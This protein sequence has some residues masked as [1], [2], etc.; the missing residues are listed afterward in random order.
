M[1][2]K[3]KLTKIRSGVR[4]VFTRIYNKID[5][6]DSDS[7]EFQTRLLELSHVHSRLEKLDNEILNELEDEVE[8]ENDIEQS[9]SYTNKFLMLKGSAKQKEVKD[10]LKENVRLP[11][12]EMPIFNGN[13]TEFMPFFE[14]FTKTIDERTDLSKIEKFSYLK[15]LLKDDAAKSIEGLALTSGNYDNAL[16]IL[17]E[18]FGNKNKIIS[19]HVKELLQL[20]VLSSAKGKALRQMC[21][22]VELHIRAL[23]TMGVVANEYTCFLKEIVLSRLPQHL[24]ISWARQPECDLGDVN[25]LMTFLKKEAS[26][27]E[28]T[29][30]DADSRQSWRSSETMRTKTMVSYATQKLNCILCQQHHHLY[31]C[32]TFHQ[33]SVTNRREFVKKKG[34][35]FRCLGKHYLKNCTFNIKCKHCNSRSHNPYLHVE[36]IDNSKSDLKEIRDVQ[37]METRNVETQV[38][39]AYFEKR[40]DMSMPILS[41]ISVDVKGKHCCE[42]IRFLLDTGSQYSFIRKNVSRK[43]G[44]RQN[45]RC[46][47]DVSGF[48]EKIVPLGECAEVEFITERNQGR[49]KLSAYESTKL[50]STVNLNV[51]SMSYPE[52]MVPLAD[53]W[54]DSSAVIDGIIGSDQY[55]SIVTGKIAPIGKGLYAIETIFGYTIGGKNETN[56]SLSW[57]KPC[58]FVSSSVNNDIRSLWELEAIGISDKTQSAPELEISVQRKD[59]RYFVAWPIKDDNLFKNMD[60]YEEQAKRRFQSILNRLRNDEFLYAEY[61]KILDDYILRGI[62][63]PIPVDEIDSS[64]PVRFLPH[65]PVVTGDGKKK[66]RIVFDASAK[67]D[68]GI[69]LND[70]METGKNINPESVEILLR[71]RMK[72]FVLIC[73]IKSA[74]LQIG[75]Q[76]Q[77][78]DM[79]RFLWLSNGNDL[80]SD[81]IPYRM[82]RMPFG[83]TASPYILAFV[84]RYHFKQFCGNQHE[85][86]QLLSTNFYVDDF[87]VSL[88][89]EHQCVEMAKTITSILADM[90]SELSKWKSNSQLVRKEYCE[91][92]DENNS[93]LGLSWTISD[94]A[95]KIKKILLNEVPNTKRKLLQAVASIHDPLGIISPFLMIGK[96]LLRETWT[97][98]L[99]WDEE[100]S[101]AMETKV[102]TWWKE[103]EH[104]DTLCFPRWIK[105]S[106]GDDIQLF[107]FSDASLSGMGCAVYF[108]I[109][110][111]SGKVYY[112][113]M[114]TKSRVSPLKPLSI[115]RMELTAAL[116]CARLAKFITQALDCNLKLHLFTDSQIALGWIRGNPRRWKTYVA[117]RV[118]E[119]QTLTSIEDWEYIPGDSNP[120]DVISRGTT[121]VKFLNS[122]DWIIGPINFLKLDEGNIMK[123]DEVSEITQNKINEEQRKTQCSC[124]LLTDNNL[125]F[126][127]CSSY[128]KAVRTFAWILRFVNKTRKICHESQLNIS[129]LEYHTAEN[130]LIR[131]H[132]CQ[133][134]S[135]EIQCFSNN[136]AI[137]NSRI[138]N[139][140][141]FIDADGILRKGGRI[142][143]SS[144]PF[145][146]KHPI[147]L[148]YSS[149]LVYL[150]IKKFHEDL[151]HAS[152]RDTIM[153]LRLRYWILRCRRAVKSVIHDCRLCRRT[154][155]LPYLPKYGPLPTDR[156]QEMNFVPFQSTGIDYIGPFHVKDGAYL[157]KCYV[158]LFT[159]CRVRAIHLECVKSMDQAT[160]I[161]TFEMFAARRGLPHV[162]RSDNFKTFVSASQIL[163]ARYRIEWKFNTPLAPWQGGFF[164]RLVRSVKIP[165]RATM[166][167]RTVPYDQ[168]KHRIT[169][170]EY[171][172]NSRPITALYDDTSDPRPLSPND[173]LINR[174]L[175][176]C[177]DGNERKDL[178]EYFLVSMKFYKFIWNRWRQEYLKALQYERKRQTSRKPEIG[179]V[180]LVES[181]G[182]K[183]I[184]P[185]AVI[186]EIFP[187]S[188]GKIRTV[189]IRTHNNRHSIRPV[190]KLSFLE[191]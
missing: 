82:K 1:A 121:D 46:E 142:E 92:D 155:A 43:L 127:N 152:V 50:C 190:Q 16:H 141:S 102:M 119:I 5:M 62:I 75:L 111:L 2:D 77:D 74:F 42:R 138:Q 59:G 33:T 17:N 28:S 54:D 49:V 125:Q 116:L 158:L 72:Q 189:K 80:E 165:L 174:G 98:K 45:G 7:Q 51:T 182:D 164:E 132:Q 23:A 115:P 47:L 37:K 118:T 73:D 114:M 76:D 120:A 129:P 183:M 89:S 27:Y 147:I 65:H 146:E 100:F 179:D 137:E 167:K 130:H 9:Y 110:K 143:F 58:V 176:I 157:K 90:K 55:Y 64:R 22:R 139:L 161:Q 169:L 135:N 126:K 105:F 14:M 84:L 188:D 109:T 101:E 160:F 96:L 34:L 83:V 52:W 38:C 67:D 136:E 24:K 108:K 93:V 57:S 19:M 168:F 191:L 21:D 69:S 12:I 48:A 60:S 113:L 85:L 187:G 44:L 178:R 144:L 36:A 159:C 87:V 151:M 63:E 123:A 95:I 61:K 170:I 171:A 15:G 140:N 163:R 53:E 81:I 117:N 66:V 25:D 154:R 13:Y 26:A 162:I 185:L 131:L 41:T 156:V 104:L 122:D 150:L 18:R 11:K 99:S 86:Y 79:T 128:T 181:P 4:S 112:S 35:C 78:K 186:T 68:K 88:D 133:H 91:N 175:A 103:V 153:S 40:N 124:N 31:Q 3:S 70:V 148:D 106:E 166:R 134:F 145:E 173:F 10:N 20:P 39:N 97:K 32:P 94:D 71:F 30:E 8:I 184:W 107:G 6:W 149:H 29:I 180:V 177:S 172:I 56:E